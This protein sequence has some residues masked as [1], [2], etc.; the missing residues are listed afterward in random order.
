MVSLYVIGFI[1]C[2][3]IFIY[4]I[5]T[6]NPEVHRIISML[7]LESFSSLP[8]FFLLVLKRCEFFWMFQYLGFWSC[9]GFVFLFFCRCFSIQVLRVV[10]GSSSCTSVDVVPYNIMITKLVAISLVEF[11]LVSFSVQYMSPCLFLLSSVTVFVTF[12]LLSSR[13]RSFTIFLLI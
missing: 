8:V 9:F 1:L 3:F 6:R 5:V 7:I 2:V 10:S 4:F 13:Y 11:S 12:G